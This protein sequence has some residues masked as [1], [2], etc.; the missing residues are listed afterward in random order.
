M[1][2]YTC[3]IRIAER[4]REREVGEK[5]KK[6]KGAEA[7]REAGDAPPPLSSLPPARKAFSHLNRG[8]SARDAGFDS[9]AQNL[10]PAAA[11]AAAATLSR[12]ES[13]VPIASGTAM[14][15]PPMGRQGE[16]TVTCCIT[17]CHIVSYCSI[18]L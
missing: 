8:P 10:P 12:W 6:E 7:G 3:C 9:V 15:D 18:S 13:A 1:I 17:V 5:G 2:K 4:E 14:P 11:A 16:D